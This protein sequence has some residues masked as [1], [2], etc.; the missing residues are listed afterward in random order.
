MTC[1][2]K[3]IF[4]NFHIFDSLQAK[5]PSVLRF[6][7][8]TLTAEMKSAIKAVVVEL[9]P[10]LLCRQSD[11]VYNQGERVADADGVLA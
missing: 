5:L 11:L 8:E 4:G 9:L 10:V 6:Y 7:R 1:F 3:F 2:D